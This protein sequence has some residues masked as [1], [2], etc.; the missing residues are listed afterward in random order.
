MFLFKNILCIHLNLIC[1]YD[2]KELFQM[3]NE[4][5]KERVEL[6]CRFNIDAFRLSLSFMCLHCSEATE[7]VP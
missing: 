1:Y 7:N 2:V 3:F 4:Q 6:I 5:T